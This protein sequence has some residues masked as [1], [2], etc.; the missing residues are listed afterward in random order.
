[1]ADN[2][3]ISHGN[4][5]LQCLG[6]SAIFSGLILRYFYVRH[7]WQNQIGLEATARLQALQSRIRPHFF[8]NC[9]NTIASLTRSDPK[10][11]EEAVEDMTDIF[12]A[13]LQESDRA[14]TVSE[15]VALCRHYLRIELH[16]LGNRLQVIWD[17]D[18]LPENAAFPALILQPIIENAIYYGIEPLVEA[19]VISISGQLTADAMIITIRNPLCSDQLAKYQSGNQMAHENI[20]QRLAVYYEKGGMLLTECDAQQYTTKIIAPYAGDS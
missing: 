5:L 6:I 13:Y 7:Q 19:G 10:L 16:R 15:E 9:M 1:M 12:R 4:F 17:I 14:W 20:R 11:A 2:K 8:F 18:C 3:I